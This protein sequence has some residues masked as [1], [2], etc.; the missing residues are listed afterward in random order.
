MSTDKHSPEEGPRS[1][2]V[3]LS[4]IDEGVLH[5][6][7]GRELQ[8]LLVDLRELAVGAKA[9]GKMVLTL[10][11]T[12][13]SN[14]IVSIDPDVVT[15]VPNPKRARAIFWLT[16][17]ANLSAQDPRQ[18][19]LPLREAPAAGKAKDVAADDRPAKSV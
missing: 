5:A 13:E 19:S 18:Q 10:G 8:K 3:I 12:V 11:I 6:E 2:G 15:K 7:L 1:F 4:Q 16:K 14:G 17:G 9:K